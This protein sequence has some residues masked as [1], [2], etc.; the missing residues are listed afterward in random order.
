MEEVLR[1]MDDLVRGG[2]V[3]YVGISDTPAWQ[4]S[5]MQAIADL[6]GWSPL[7]ALEIEYSL[8]ERT[9]ERDLIPMASEMGLGV[10]PWSPLGRGVLTGKYTSR[11]LDHGGDSAGVEGTRLGS[12]EMNGS[13]TERSLAIAEVVKTVATEL[14]RTPPQVA[15][16][17]TL[18]NDSVTAPLIGARRLSQ[19]EDNLG[20]LEVE[21]P[22]DA[23]ARLEQAS[24]VA[25]GFPHD[26]LVRPST[27][28]AVFGHT[29]VS[30]RRPP[31][32]AA[33]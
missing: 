27:M 17:W 8:I 16:A 18:L 21:L 30:A 23:R 20:A 3:L 33:R 28:A 9:G 19:L 7:V 15:L 11:D 22:D 12:G 25:L 10:I 26:V 24:T 32:E 29:K 14:G 6:R 4:V 13:L 5:R 2:K 1:A 31:A